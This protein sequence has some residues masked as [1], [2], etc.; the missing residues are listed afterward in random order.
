MRNQG[1]TRVLF[2]AIMLIGSVVVQG[3]GQSQERTMPSRDSDPVLSCPA[4]LL[5]M[6][7]YL[8]HQHDA[9]ELSKDDFILYDN[10]MRHDIRFWT[11][12]QKS[13]LDNDGAIYALGYDPPVYDFDNKLHKI[14][15]VVQTNAKKKLRVQ[16]SPRSYRATK[17]FFDGP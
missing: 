6:M 11:R 10:G 8:G 1:N 4:Y 9:S 14:R 7:V 17:Q 13:G 2:L 15:V 16:F 3:G 12:I 5:T